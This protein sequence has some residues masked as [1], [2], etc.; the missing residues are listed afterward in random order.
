MILG[1][2][3]AGALLA[4]LVMGGFSAML[5]FWAGRQDNAV[6]IQVGRRAFYGATASTVLA[7][8]RGTSPFSS[9]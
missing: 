3:G 9:K 1:Y 7:G 4:A 2:L 8:R 5:S 6:L